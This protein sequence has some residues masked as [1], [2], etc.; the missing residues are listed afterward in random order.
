M[1]FK[2][3]FRAFMLVAAIS[4]IAVSCKED[5]PGGFR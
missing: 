3:I 5:G 2:S 4:S 1:K